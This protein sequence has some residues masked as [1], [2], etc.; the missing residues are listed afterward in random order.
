MASGRMRPP[1]ARESPASALQS[2]RE[3]VFPVSE[4][5][6][7]LSSS[8]TPSRMKNRLMCWFVST[9]A[10]PAAPGYRA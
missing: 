3:L 1:K 8:Q 5:G 9:D 6:P 10:I 2:R 4:N 7:L